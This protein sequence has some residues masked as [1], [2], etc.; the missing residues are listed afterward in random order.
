MRWLRRIGL[1]VLLPVAALAAPILYVEAACRPQGAPQAYASLLPE[2]DRRPEARTLLTWPE[3]HVVHAYD[4]YARVIAEGPPHAYG[5]WSSIRGF[6]DGLCAMSRASGP[7]GGFDGGT[8]QMAYVVGASFTAELAMKA[9]YEETVGRLFAMGG[10]SEADAISAAQA[11]DYAA[12]LTQT[13]WYLY[14]FREDTAE[15][16]AAT[17]TLRDAERRA[18]LGIEYRAKALYGGVIEEAVGAVGADALTM[19]SVIAGIDPVALRGMEDVTVVGSIAEGAVIETPRYRAFTEMLPVLAEA[20][21]R[22]VEIAGNDEIMLTALADAP[23]EDALRSMERQGYGDVR[24][25]IL[26]PVSELLDFVRDPG[27]PRLEHVHDY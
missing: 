25:L 3:W 11:A 21:G 16:S 13:P 20:G 17:G 7:H 23:Y 10:R 19:R 2:R 1:L 26:M 22:F 5:F 4:D 9:L 24:S 14:D 27:P 6:W 12:F 18:A 8:K 15:L